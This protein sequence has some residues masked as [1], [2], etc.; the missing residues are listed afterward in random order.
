M[1]IILRY[2]TG[3]D[4]IL[5]KFFFNNLFFPLFYIRGFEVDISR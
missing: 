2:F 5:Y 4:E 3:L 1:D